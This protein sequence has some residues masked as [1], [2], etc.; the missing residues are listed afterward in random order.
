ML[1]VQALA[2]L[3]FIVWSTILT[4]V[5]IKVTSRSRNANKTQQTKPLEFQGV[6]KIIPFRLTE[7]EELLGADY[8]E[9]NIHHSGVG[10]SRA[11]SVLKKHDQAVELNLVPVGKNKGHMDYLE[12]EYGTKL[13]QVSTIS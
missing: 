2:C 5:L 1:G 13:N 3:C 6:D 10:V 4:F 11:I 7:H 12:K 9:H 8:T